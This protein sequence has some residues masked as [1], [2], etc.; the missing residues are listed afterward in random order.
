MTRIRDLWNER[1]RVSQANP[2]AWGVLALVVLWGLCA[3]AARDPEG[4]DWNDRRV[5]LTLEIDWLYALEADPKWNGAEIELSAGT[6]LDVV[7]I[8]ENEGNQENSPRKAPPPAR[9]RPLGALRKGRIRA[10]IEAPMTSIV[11]V[12]GGGR[13]IPI[14]LLAILDGPRRSELGEPLQV[15]VSRPEWDAVNLSVEG[16]RGES[17]ILEPGTITRLKVGV[18]LFSTLAL[19][20]PARLSLEL[21][22]IRGGEAVWRDERRGMIA[23]NNAADSQPSREFQIPAPPVE[24]T[25]RLDIILSWDAPVGEQEGGKRL[26]RLMRWWRGGVAT[27][28]VGRR[29]TL[30]VVDPRETEPIPAAVDP[31][32]PIAGEIVD[33]FDA[34]A[35]RGKLRRSSISGKTVAADD[36]ALTWEIPDGVFAGERRHE[37]LRGIL[38]RGGEPGRIDESQGSECGWIAYP[39]KVKQPGK[40]HRLKL[41]IKEGRAE[42]LGVLL[43]APPT[44][45]DR[46]R[47]AL[48]ASASSRTEWVEGGVGSTCFSWFVWPETAEPVL[49]VLNRGTSAVR[50]GAVELEEIGDIPTT[51]F[52]RVAEGTATRSVGLRL[53]DRRDWDRFGGGVEG[54]L[55]DVVA[56]AKRLSDYAGLCG[57]SL[58]VLPRSVKPVGDRTAIDGR[59]HEDAFRPDRIE[60]ATL[61]LD[62]RNITYWLE[63]SFDGLSSRSAAVDSADA[64][65]EAEA[66]LGDRD[67]VHGRSDQPL[68]EM[69]QRA[70]IRSISELAG[71]HRGRKG[72]GGILVRL[73]T[74]GTLPGEVGIGIDDETYKRFFEEALDQS[75]VDAGAPAPTS[76]AADR[77]AQRSA[78]FLGGGRDPWEKWRSRRIGQL[79]AKL[80][81]AAAAAAPGTVF[82]VATPGVDEGAAG[83]EARKVDREGSSARTAWRSIGLDPTQWPKN[84]RSLILLRGVSTSAGGLRRDLSIDSELDAEVASYPR[85][86]VLLGIDDLAARV[87][88]GERT[89]SSRI[90]A[91]FADPATCDE[92][93]AHAIAAYDSRWVITGLA[94]AS[95]REDSLRRFAGLLGSTP[96]PPETPAAPPLR[97]GVACR[98]LETNNQTYLC[99]ANDTPYEVRV[100][101]SV[102]APAGAIVETGSS[103]PGIAGFKR[104]EADRYVVELPPRGIASPRFKATGLKV[105]VL[106]AN[107]TEESLKIAKVRADELSARLG[108]SIRSSEVQRVSVVAAVPERR[109]ARRVI[110]AA[111]HAYQE[112]RLAEFARL[113]SSH[114]VDAA[115]EDAPIRTGDASDLPSNRRR[116]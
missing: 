91:P 67:E 4:V 69:V 36:E 31:A 27:R 19:E 54:G 50:L 37:R 11:I 70:M 114:W 35:A 7:P 82:A 83:V 57:A 30:A 21:K 107:A 38:G 49:V 64:K 44:P 100:L 39:L 32:A 56:I 22:P 104:I 105:A 110:L 61:I 41:T 68:N 15:T 60:V 85:R 62:R 10:R 101:L 79:Y 43:L 78:F 95:G 3:R 73:G 106:A 115:V 113:A 16:G 87:E 52:A 94:A 8:T 77:F 98:A 18:N 58:V 6:I 59:F 5:G 17:G 20:V 9:I 96:P 34:G 89:R 103:W 13:S 111:V 1:K 99:L 86:G 76:L 53:S 75:A 81:A 92:L 45:G 90:V 2:K 46:G 93:T 65:R 102:S 97:I 80:A 116:R 29:V 12:R 84:E 42:S 47:A 55:E 24:G 33:F 88:R 14:P 40:L 112:N 66:R 72:F 109:N 51:S 108:Q 26:G 74:E 71:A 25:Y 23:T 63:T 28:T 48:E